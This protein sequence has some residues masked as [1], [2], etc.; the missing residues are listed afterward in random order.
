M[1][2]RREKLEFAIEVECG[3]LIPDMSAATRATVVSGSGGGAESPATRTISGRLR[4][5]PTFREN[6]GAKMCGGR[7]PHTVCGSARS[8]SSRKTSNEADTRT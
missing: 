8:A 6:N 7:L 1:A 3:K 5:T 4:I 2:S